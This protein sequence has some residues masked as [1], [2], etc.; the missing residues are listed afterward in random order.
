[1]AAVHADASEA[2][3]ALAAGTRDVDDLRLAT[4]IIGVESSGQARQIPRKLL[5]PTNRYRPD[6]SQSSEYSSAKHSSARGWPRRA[7][8]G[9]HRGTV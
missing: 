2:V 3:T 6:P 7:H 4:N 8:H 9:R 1:V 5:R